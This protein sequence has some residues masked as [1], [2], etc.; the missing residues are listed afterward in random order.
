MNTKNLI[1]L[2]AGLA[3]CAA[4][5]EMMDR[6]SGIK[7]GQRMTLRPY[8]AVSASYDSNA[9][10]RDGGKSDVVWMV[11]PGLG[12]EYKAENWSILASANYQYNEY[13]KKRNSNNNSHHTFGETLTYNW[14]NSQAG[15]RGWSVMLTEQ[16]RQVNEVDDIKDVGGNSYNRDR[17]EGSVAGAIQRRFG[18][19]LHAGI[20]GGYSW[21]DYDNKNKA[22][23]GSGLYG[24]DRWTA[25]GE[26]GYAPSKWTD[27]LLVG[28]Y[29]AY[30]QDGNNPQPGV[31]RRTASRDSESY[32]LQAGIGTFATE[33]ITYRVLGGWSKYEYKSGGSSSDGFI[34]T[35]AANW[36]ISDTWRT[37]LMA[38]SSYQPS[39]REYSS[40]SRVDSISWGVAHAMVQGKLNGTFDLA[41]RREG[42][43]CQG[44]TGGTRSYDY[45]LD[46]FTARLGLSYTL[47]RYL[48]LF[49]N[50][51]YRMSRPSSTNGGGV[52]YDYDR[53]RGTLGV[54]LTY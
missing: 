30:N 47:N 29:S 10:G 21:V 33:R 36:T 43:E 6:P 22:T 34:Y 9:A 54:R 37:M 17:R 19:G 27:L 41:Y 25:G 32:A 7:I 40:S 49:T 12:L 14:S 8:V 3:T 20:N 4:S 31:M 23:S 24:Y 35:V 44:Y 46:I 48:S 28:S 2:V 39:E 11:N 50:F 15:E 42:R 18:H 16:Y 53:F 51:E 13:T 5:A 38:S 26:I 52:G 1:L 45:D